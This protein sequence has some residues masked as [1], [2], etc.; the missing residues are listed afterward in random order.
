MRMLYIKG[1]PHRPHGNRAFRVDCK[2]TSRIGESSKR[3]MNRIIASFL[4]LSNRF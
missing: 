2:G 1:D 4:L 3:V